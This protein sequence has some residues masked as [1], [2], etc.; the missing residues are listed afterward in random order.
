MIGCV[1]HVIHDGASCLL[2]VDGPCLHGSVMQ[3]VPEAVNDCIS[4][5]VPGHLSQLGPISAAPPTRQYQCVFLSREGAF[6]PTIGQKIKELDFV[7]GLLVGCELLKRLPL[8]LESPL[9]E[10]AECRLLL[11]NRSY[12]QNFIHLIIEIA[13]IHVD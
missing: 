3:F 7:A 11:T 4:A 13:L 9:V 5:A 8:T 10:K 12:A 2:F 6:Q 1:N